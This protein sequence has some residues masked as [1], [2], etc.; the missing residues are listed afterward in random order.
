MC[1]SGFR[2]F[3]IDLDSF[4]LFFLAGLRA[5]L[6]LV[7]FPCAFL[8]GASFDG[9]SRKFKLAMALT[10]CSCWVL[11]SYCFSHGFLSPLVALKN[12]GVA[13]LS[14]SVSLALK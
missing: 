12:F 7:F 9:D 2:L 6:D 10:G 13:L 8:L 11:A 14:L 5:S 1:G 3:G 4:S